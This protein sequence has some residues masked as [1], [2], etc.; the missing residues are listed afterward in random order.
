MTIKAESPKQ[1]K[2]LLHNEISLTS[3]ISLISMIC[4]MGTSFFNQKNNFQLLKAA[5][6]PMVKPSRANRLKT[7]ASFKNTGGHFHR[8]KT[9]PAEDGHVTTRRC[10][11]PQGTLTVEG[12]RGRNEFGWK[13]KLSGLKSDQLNVIPHVFSFKTLANCVFFRGKV[14]FFCLKE[15]SSPQKV[16][17]KDLPKIP[18]VFGGIELS[19]RQVSRLV[20]QKERT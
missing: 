13:S 2:N 8:G 9:N 7:L 19:L 12:R 3:L 20:T 1:K 16:E 18:E 15:K 14:V 6:F 11:G 4:P 5:K 17:T 10:T